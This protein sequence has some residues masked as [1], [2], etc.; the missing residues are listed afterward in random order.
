MTG[1]PVQ[2]SFKKNKFMGFKGISIEKYIR[3]HIK[4]NPN[5]DKADLKLR[6]K[7]ALQ[8]FK[9]GIKC[10]C[11]NDIWVV[12]SA[13]VG[14]SCFTCITGESEPIDDVE[15]EN[16][17]YK[18]KNRKGEKSIDEIEPNKIHGIFDDDGYQVHTDLINK[19]SLC[20]TCQLDHDPSEELF[21]NMTRLD[22]QNEQEFN[23]FAYRKIDF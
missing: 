23:C 13:T 7:Q 3:L 10:S 16:A 11:G 12:G 15:I 2:H 4:N 8:D 20:L 1:K 21:C 19:P 5:E 6:L 22:Q 18:K 17:L 14:N 9:N